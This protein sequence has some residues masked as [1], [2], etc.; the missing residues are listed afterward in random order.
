MYYDVVNI[1]LLVLSSDMR[2]IDD[3]CRRSMLGICVARKR[4]SRICMTGIV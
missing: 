4:L 1:C 3:F 2:I